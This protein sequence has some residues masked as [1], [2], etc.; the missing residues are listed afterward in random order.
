M[1]EKRVC[2]E[3]GQVIEGDD[4][5]ITSEGSLCYDCY[6]ESFCF[7]DECG[8]IIR[9]DDSVYMDGSLLC[10]DCL[11]E[12]Y[13]LCNSCREWT[14]NDGLTRVRGG[15]YICEYCLDNDY[16]YCE[17]CEEYVYCD[18]YDCEEEL[19]HECLENQTIGEYHSHHYYKIGEAEPRKNLWHK[20]IELEIDNGEDRE[21]L[22]GELKRIANTID[23]ERIYFERDGSLDNGFEII[24]QPFLIGD[25]SIEWEKILKKCIDYGF[26]S[27]DAGTCGLHLHYDRK[28]FGRTFS[29]QTYHIGKIIAFYE[30]FWNDLL[31]ASRRTASQ[32]EQWAKRYYIDKPEEATE[33]VKKG[34]S[35][36]Y[37]AVNLTKGVTIEFRLGRGTLNI[38]SFNAWNDLHDCIVK[39]VKKATYKNIDDL[40]IW[41]KG[42]KQSTLDYLHSKN[43][44]INF[45]IK[46]E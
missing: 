24:T 39:N 40:S 32:Y 18:E 19:C 9:A 42:I 37:H 27:H 2:F 34:N 17:Q 23:A 16:Y 38:N 14:H 44:F 35:E 10:N 26:T 30:I 45:E 1:E 46:G 25:N 13:T 12:N 5:Y 7:C 29:Q 15:D 8:E 22:A 3:C 33:I 4:F 43:A 28:F 20:G 36:R 31:K 11:T 41:L 21:E 6:E